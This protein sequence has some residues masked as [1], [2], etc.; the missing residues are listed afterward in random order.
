MNLQDYFIDTRTKLTATIEALFSYE[1]G[2][3]APFGGSTTAFIRTLSEFAVSGKM[4]RG[5]LGRLGADLFTWNNST[6]CVGS[7]NLLKLCAALELFQAGLLAHDDIMDQDELR[8]GK[9]TLHKRFEAEACRKMP[10]NE[11]MAP[12]RYPELARFGESKGICAGDIFFFEAWKLLS[13]ADPKLAPDLSSLFSRELID[14]CLAQIADVNF[15]TIEVFPSLDEILEVYTYK[16]ARYTITLPLCAGAIF[17]GRADVISAL[18]AISAPLGIVFQLQDDYLGLFGSE[19][20]IG[21]PIGSDIREGKKT[22]YMILLLPTLTS[23]EKSRFFSI[24]GSDKISIPD[25]DYVRGLVIAHG[26]DTTLHSMIQSYAERTSVALEAF[27]KEVND[28]NSDIFQLLKDFVAY[29]LSRP[30]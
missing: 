19:E 11:R 9:P 17:A 16:T 24:F 10:F 15:G 13:E 8:R 12:Y 2:T 25:L 28:F 26:I 23:I 4:L 29:S 5:I 1:E 7:S 3:V 30:Y 27:S 18:E 6:P 21:K 22:P 20:L 14:V